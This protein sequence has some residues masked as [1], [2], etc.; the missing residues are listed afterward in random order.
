[1]NFKFIQIILV[2]HSLKIIELKKNDTDSDIPK[3]TQK[4][5]QEEIIELNDSNFD[6]IIQNGNNNRWLIFFYLETCYHCHRARGVLNRLFDDKGYKNKK[7]IKFA[8]IEIETN[9]ETTFRFGINKVPFIILV[10]NNTMYELDTYINEKTLITFIE[11]NFTNVTSDLKPFPRKKILKYYYKLFQDSLSLVLDQTNNYLE[12]K[13]IKFKFN[14]I[15]FMLSYC[16]ICFAFW[17]A[18]VYLFIKC[19]NLIN[20][21]Q[22]KENLQALSQNNN[23]KNILNE[24]NNEKNK[25]IQNINMNEEEKKKIIEENKEKEEQEKNVKQSNIN[26]DKS[27][28]K[29]KKE[30]KE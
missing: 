19:F 17:V 10:E 25:N 1:M 26:N 21:R 15:T 12:S 27:I 13:N 29:E 14:G 3:D 24:D 22:T 9:S 28:T 4:E 7:N 23:N 20:N 6:S 11:T 18:V 16:I 30:K 5:G 8:S 2:L